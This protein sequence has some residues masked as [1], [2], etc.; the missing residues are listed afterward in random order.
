MLQQQACTLPSALSFEA[1][2]AAAFLKITQKCLRS[3]HPPPSPFFCLFLRNLTPPDLDQPFFW[4]FTHFGGFK[5]STSFIQVPPLQP[6]D[7]CVWVKLNLAW[8]L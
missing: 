8:T 1:E 4:D 6:L 2:K 7:E 5:W 3:F